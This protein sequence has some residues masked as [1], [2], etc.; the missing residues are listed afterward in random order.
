MNYNVSTSIPIFF[1]KVDE[2]VIDARFTP[3]KIY[4]CHTLENLNGSYFSKEVLTKMAETLG[5]IP[6]LGYITVDNLNESDFNGHE[7]KLIITE[8]DIEMVYIGRAYGIIPE[9]HNARFEM[10]LCEDNITREFLVCDGF[11]WNKFKECI[12]IFDRDGSKSQSMEL[13]PD[14]IQG[15]FQKD[16]LFHF[17]SATC[18]GA[19]ILGLGIIPAMTGSVVEKFSL[20]KIDSQISELKDELIKFQKNNTVE[21]VKIPIVETK[22]KCPHCYN[23]IGEKELYYD[24]NSWFHSPCRHIG[25]IA[26]PDEDKDELLFNFNLQHNDIAVA[27]EIQEGGKN[28]DKILEM[29]QKYNLTVEDLASKDI[30]VEE[31]SLEELEEKVKLFGDST[32]DVV[33]TDFSLT[34]EQLEDEL[35]RELAE[36][37]TIVEDYYGEIYTSPRYYYSDSKPDQNIVVA[38]DSKNCY[39]VGF[40]YSVTGDNVEVDASTVVR[41]KVDLNPMELSSDTDGGV[42]VDDI[43]SAFTSKAKSD[44]MISAKEKFMTKQFEA[45]KESAIAELT[46]KFTDLQTKFDE[47]QTQFSLTNTELSAK[48]Q[49]E[50]EDSENAIFDSFSKS[51]TEE[52]M[53]EIKSKKSEFSL[54]EIDDKLTLILGRKTRRTSAINFTKVDTTKPLSY[55]IPLENKKTSGK[56]YD[57]LFEKFSKKEQE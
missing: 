42:E 57:D 3:V 7:Q 25:D 4:L 52:D 56:E 2:Q 28:L 27:K 12:D 51:L 48:L 19:C 37:E 29:L 53:A 26:F 18:E 43:F 41:Y 40:S 5:N 49:T 39:L 44:F 46:S 50:R 23:F 54:Q 11:L 36:I 15:S 30:K 45:E 17:T 13:E 33:S 1:E 9:T 21:I 22:W 31:F 55:Q 6:I 8:N 14:S 10:K 32:L 34:S 47:L 16:N 35:R 38:W 20:S 24:G